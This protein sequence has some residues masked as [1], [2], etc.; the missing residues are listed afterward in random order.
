MKKNVYI[1]ILW[2][3]VLLLSIASAVV[4]ATRNKTDSSMESIWEVEVGT[5]RAIITG[6]SDDAYLKV[7]LHCDIYRPLALSSFEEY[8]LNTGKPTGE[9]QQVRGFRLSGTDEFVTALNDTSKKYAYIKNIRF[10]KGNY[11]DVYEK[12]MKVCI[13]VG[14]SAK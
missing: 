10:S 5:Q 8:S 3:V 13:G 11:S 12:A 7:Y 9:K 2:S 6:M 4:A 14:A 1:P